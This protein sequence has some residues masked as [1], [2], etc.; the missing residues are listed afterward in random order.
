MPVRNKVM[1]YREAYPGLKP[2]LDWV[3]Y[4]VENGALVFQ[5]HPESSDHGKYYTA[6]LL[7]DAPIHFTDK[8]T[9]LTGVA[10]IPE[11]F[12]QVGRPGRE[13][14]RAQ[15]QY[16]AGL[17]AA[18]LWGWGESD[19]HCPPEL[20]R[21]GTTLFY[22]KNLAKADILSA[23]KSGMMVA[24]MGEDFQNIYV[25]EFSVGDGKPADK[26]IMFGESVKFSGPAVVRFSLNKD[27]PEQEVLLI[28][29]G[30]VI[31]SSKR[32]KF[33]YRDEEAAKN[34]DKVFYR[35]EVEGRGPMEI[36]KGNRLF[37]NPIFVDWKK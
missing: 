35:V 26:N 36:E 22:V 21:H 23:M 30:K 29:N 37:T 8:I 7:A 4:M 13:W 34:K 2:Y 11:G 6:M 33:E 31:F 5:A 25:T 12:T 32:G 28:R 3:D 18:P 14:D 15:L 10:I 20:L 9:N 19:Y 24:L 1:P 16:M 27:A 17:R